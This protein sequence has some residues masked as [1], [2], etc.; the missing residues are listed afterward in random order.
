MSGSGGPP[1]NRT[2][3]RWNW[4]FP[5]KKKNATWFENTLNHFYGYQC[6]HIENMIG[7]ICIER[8]MQNYQ[9]NKEIPLKR[10]KQ[11]ILYCNDCFEFCVPLPTIGRRYVPFK[12]GFFDRHVPSSRLYL[13]SS[14]FVIVLEH[15]AVKIKCMCAVARRCDTF[16]ILDNKNLPIVFDN[17]TLDLL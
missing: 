10:Y 1:S 6:Y 13:N 12:T 4:I 3:N 9:K 5:K 15:C 11:R 17:D 2:G 8:S 16:K 14:P 7:K